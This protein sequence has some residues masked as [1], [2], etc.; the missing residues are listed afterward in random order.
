MTNITKL[1]GISI[2]LFIT[3]MSFFLFTFARPNSASAGAGGPQ[4]R[5]CVVATSTAIAVGN[6]FATVISATTT[7]RAWIRI[8]SPLNATNTAYVGFDDARATV[9]SG[10]YLTP[11]TTSSPVPYVE[12]GLNTDFPTDGA[13]RILTSTGSSTILVTECLYK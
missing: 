8:E 10:F 13:V 4:A 7:N 3:A 9:A 2:A 11:A 6:Q 1:I 12:Y 5:K